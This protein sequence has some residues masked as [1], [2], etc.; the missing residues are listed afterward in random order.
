MD[1]QII[2]TDIDKI[3]AT[4]VFL[5]PVKCTINEKQQWR[6]VAVGFEDESFFGDSVVDP[7][8]YANN[9]EDML[10]PTED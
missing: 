1:E 4:G 10:N 2:I 5:Q 8:E 7:V 6:W 9:L 3:F